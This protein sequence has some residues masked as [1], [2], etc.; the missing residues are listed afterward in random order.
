MRAVAAIGI[1]CGLSP[2][3]VAQTNPG[4]DTSP[5]STTNTPAENGALPLSG[6]PSPTVEGRAHQAELG[7]LAERQ[8]E[9]DK[10]LADQKEE[11]VSRFVSG[12]RLPQ[13]IK[14]DAGKKQIRAEQNRLRREL[15]ALQEMQRVLH[16]KRLKDYE[17]A[18]DRN[19]A[20]ARRQSRGGES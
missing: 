13:K 8:R 16:E 6:G 15:N 4:N 17:D 12:T 3:V 14:A 5:G 20:N 11:H 18:D 9:A 10:A 2:A 7:L 19:R 1:L